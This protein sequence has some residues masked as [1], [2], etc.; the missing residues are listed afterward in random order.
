MQ[1]R[2]ELIINGSLCASLVAIV[3]LYFSEEIIEKRQLKTRLTLWPLI[4]GK[5]L[6]IFAMTLGKLA[7]HF[8][9]KMVLGSS[10]LLHSY[11]A[12][13]PTNNVK[14]AGAIEDDLD[15]FRQMH[16][17]RYRGHQIWISVQES[18]CIILGTLWSLSVLM[19]NTGDYPEVKS[20]LL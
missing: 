8:K 13:S 10:E 9:L 12:N 4:V 11:S 14:M 18:F 2:V 6:L 3:F 1:N 16:Y 20:K 15:Q 5:V 7:T 19:L 17:V